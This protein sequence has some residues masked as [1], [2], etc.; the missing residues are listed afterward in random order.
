ML[1]TI[2][3]QILIP[4]KGYVGTKAVGRICKQVL[5]QTECS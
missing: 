3:N 1:F 4:V 2:E 5:E